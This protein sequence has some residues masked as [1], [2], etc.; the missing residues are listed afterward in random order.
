MVFR[1][2]MHAFGAGGPSVDTVLERSDCRPGELL[3]GEVRLRGGDRTVTI[4]RIELG[5]VT[6]VEFEGGEHESAGGV[7]FAR[8][9]LS[10]RFEL[11]EH[12]DQVLPFQFAVPWEAPVTAVFGQPLRGM[13]VGLKTEVSVA[14]AID[15]GDLD[16]VAIH[17]L[18]AQELFLDAVARLGFTFRNADVEYGHLRGVPQQMP[19]YQEIE[20]FPAPQYAGRLNE[21]EVTFV[22]GPQAVDVVLEVDKRGGLFSG[23]ADT[24][25]HLRID[26]ATAGRTDWA[27]YLD[28][29]LQQ[30]LA[31]AHSYGGHSPYGHGGYESHGAYGAYGHH[32]HRRHRGGMGMGAVAGAAA[33][34][35]VGGIVADEVFEEV[36][37]DDGGDDGFF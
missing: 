26:Y 3:R 13:A 10:G 19:F 22:A 30:L 35:F 16:P 17:P 31:N 23:G 12:A 28:G 15:A 25:H 21:L 6:R 24:F 2:L 36:F 9:P 37:D 5:L 20:F 11:A 14:K 18:P 29:W 32:G 34:G 7:E 27:G 8:L 1:K 33:A 4:E